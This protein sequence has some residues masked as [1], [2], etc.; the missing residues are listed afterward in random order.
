[1]ELPSLKH[2]YRQARRSG[3]LHLAARELTQFPLEVCRL[4]EQLDTNEKFW[5]CVDLLKID[6]SH[7]S[8]GHLPPE[9]QSL[10]LLISFKFSQNQLT[11]LPESFYELTALQVLDL[12]HNRL[13]EPLSHEIRRLQN[14][15]VLNLSFNALTE[16]P[17]SLCDL[18][19]LEHL[20]VE[21]NHLSV[22]PDNFG[23][24]KGL[25]K[26]NCAS[27]QLESFPQSFR[28]CVQLN[29]LKASNNH[30]VSFEPDCF[31]YFQKLMVLDVRQNRIGHC[32]V[33]P[34]SSALA[35]VFLSFN[36]LS[37]LPDD[38]FFPLQTCLVFLDLG[39]NQLKGLPRSISY[40]TKLKTCDVTNNNLSDL[41]YG[42]GP[43]VCVI[44]YVMT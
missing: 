30:L 36:Q 28:Q 7:N 3:A 19:T 14:L 44:C 26:F 5:E 4:E 25:F 24:L 16:L 43:S 17:S 27:N 21:H 10:E 35:Q 33:F 11:A 38:A 32:P 12:S 1:M 41:P 2:A 18:S 39:N 40:L 34:Q 9:I 31:V 6:M 15:K 29:D 8:I 42:L 37:A 20:D 23:Q 13:Q 22:L